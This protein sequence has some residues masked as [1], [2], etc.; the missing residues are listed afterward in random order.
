MRTPY[1]WYWVRDDV[2]G[3]PFK[4]VKL[5]YYDPAKDERKYEDA[6]VMAMDD[7][8]DLVNVFP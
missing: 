1:L 4:R 7:F 3:H 2:F 8:G 5:A 6:G